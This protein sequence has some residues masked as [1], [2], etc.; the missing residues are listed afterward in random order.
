MQKCEEEDELS[1]ISESLIR[2]SLDSQV[3][4]AANQEALKT[5]L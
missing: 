1:Q 4:P 3:P 2:V 5:E